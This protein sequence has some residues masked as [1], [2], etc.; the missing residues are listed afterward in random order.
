[1]FLGAIAL[2]AQDIQ[3]IINSYKIRNVGPL[4]GGRVTAVEGVAS[5]PSVFYMGATG[6]GVWKTEDYGISWENIS[7][8]YFATP[9]IGAISVHQ[10]DPNIIYV[11]TG[12][13]EPEIIVQGFLSPL[14]SPA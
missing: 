6:G 13:D 2:E 4:R 9:S 12:S 14:Q 1:M 3:D 10:N 7:D 5:Q 8:G 11:G